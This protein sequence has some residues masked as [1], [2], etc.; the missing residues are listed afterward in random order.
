AARPAM[1]FLMSV[2]PA[3]RYTRTPVPGPIMRFPPDGSAAAAQQP[4]RQ[5]APPGCGR[6]P[7]EP[8]PDGPLPARRYRPTAPAVPPAGTPP[9][10]LS[11][12]PLGRVPGAIG[13]PA[14]D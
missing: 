14:G 1:P 3:A 7:A 13:R 8:R 4:A 6:S 10:Q 12:I 9:A 11:A 2:T 5:S